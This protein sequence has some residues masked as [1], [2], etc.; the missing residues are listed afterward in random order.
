M[1]HT[2]VIKT[3]QDFLDFKS[4]DAQPEE[5][6]YKIFNMY[7]QVPREQRIYGW[8]PQSVKVLKISSY[9]S[10]KFMIPDTVEELHLD[11]RWD[12][13]GVPDSVKKLVLGTNFLGKISQWPAGLE[14]LVINGWGLDDS[15]EPIGID[16]LPETV[17]TVFLGWGTAV[18][19]R[20]WPQGLQKFT[21]QTRE[22]DPMVN[23]LCTE[24]VPVPAGAE[25][26]H[27]IVE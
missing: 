3:H 19:F 5:V 18:E 26:D 6:E 1:T 15:D 7:S 21:L 8:I 23:W 2:I 9:F 13:C 17:K 27:V 12:D 24:H 14:E 10:E 11:H 22:D 20:A 16:N 4:S 25:F